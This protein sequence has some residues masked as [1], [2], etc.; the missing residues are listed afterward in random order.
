MDAYN[1]YNNDGSVSGSTKG[2]ATLATEEKTAAD[3]AVKARTSA[4]ATDGG[5][6]TEGR[7]VAQANWDAAK[8]VATNAESSLTAALSGAVLATLRQ[9]VEDDTAAWDAQ[10]VILAGLIADA[11][12]AENEVTAA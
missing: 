2:T 12:T 9:T 11:D 5:V 4:S 8:N 1:E 6:L 3:L 7:A 10:Q